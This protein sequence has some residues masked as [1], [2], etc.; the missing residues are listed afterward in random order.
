MCAVQAHMIQLS[1][2][3]S[4]QLA[5]MSR[6]FIAASSAGFP[7][8]T[9]FNDL[10]LNL[11]RED[12]GVINCSIRSFKQSIL[13]MHPQIFLQRISGRMELYSW[14]HALLGSCV[15]NVIKYGFLI[16][17]RSDHSLIGL[18]SCSSRLSVHPKWFYEQTSTNGAV[19]RTMKTFP[20]VCIVHSDVLGMYNYKQIV[21]QHCV[22]CHTRSSDPAA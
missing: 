12:C 11:W 18:L 3:V 20:S 22:M 19:L 1:A 16:W 14:Q 10:A 2:L 15:G 9:F 13:I 17:A 6:D 7:S 4:L 21:K 8:G 5:I